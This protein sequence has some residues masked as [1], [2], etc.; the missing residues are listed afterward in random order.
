MRAL[1]NS[2]DL[3]SIGVDYKIYTTIISKRLNTFI[4]EI[5][6]ED[7]TGFVSQ[8]QT[9]DNIRRTLHIVDH[10]QKTKQSTVLVSIDA[11]KAFDRV[12]WEFLYQI[13]E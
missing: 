12:N 13:L 2:L 7:Q 8:R 1:L 4:S 11:E 9:Q 3:P 6:E 10:A 5:I